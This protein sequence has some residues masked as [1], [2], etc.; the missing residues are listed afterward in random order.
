[1]YSIAALDPVPHSPNPLLPHARMIVF[2]VEVEVELAVEVE[3]EV[4]E[5]ASA[6][7]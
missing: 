3:A 4:G 7:V 2:K 6:T 1:M 5:R